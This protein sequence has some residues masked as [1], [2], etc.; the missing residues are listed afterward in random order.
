VAIRSLWL[1][2]VIASAM[3]AEARAQESD[4]S[5]V[6]FPPDFFA[7]FSPQTALD[8]VERVPGFTI[9]EGTERRGFAGAAGNVWID[10]AAPAVKSEDLDEILDRIP[11]RDVVRIELIRG[12]GASASNAQSV[13]VNVVRR[14]SDGAGVWEFSLQQ[15][16]GGEVS[17]AGQASWSGRRGAVEY[18]L[19]AMFEDANTPLDGAEL[20]YDAGVVLDER[21]VEHIE[22][23]ERERRIS[24]ELTSPF[25][26]GA[27]ALTGVL[28]SDEGDERHNLRS[29]DELGVAEGSEIVAAH[30]REEIGEVG[31]AYT[32]VLGA[33]ETELAALVTRRRLSEEEASVEY[34]ELGAFDESESEARDVESGETILRANAEREFAE[35]VSLSAGAEIALNTLDQ[36]LALT[37]DDGSGPT[38]VN[39]PGANVNIEEWRGEAFATLGLRALGWRMEAGAAVETSRLTQ[40][41]DVS[42]TMSLTYWKPSLQL[43]RPMGDDDQLR[44]RFYRDVG[45][46]DFEDFAAS[47]E[48][49]GGGGVFAGNPNLRPET[50]WRAEASSDWRFEEGAFELTLYYWRIED[51]LDYAPVGPPGDRFDARGN[52]G[53]ASLW[54]M[55][56][57]F[58]MPVPILSGANLRFEGVWQESEATDPLTGESRAQSEIRE[59]FVSVAFRQDLPGF[60]LAWGFDFERERL[61]PEYRFDRITRENDAD[62]TELWIESTHFDGV[63]LRVFAANLFNAEEARDR[64]RFYPDR[65]A[66]LDSRE[67][68]ERELGRVFGVELRGSF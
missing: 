18:T 59:S 32:R 38:L 40:S 53:E 7:S 15:S 48:L 60:S 22:E 52:I 42:N 30:E 57:A 45:Q 5:R 31:A 64:T 55:R 9:N 12:E 10:G 44:F 43:S 49:S 4:V 11:A 6:V 63:K 23:D 25:A 68:R 24:G 13:R 62:D 2:T 66:V 39:V 51:A 50:S 37:E 17:P 27:I 21:D 47:A 46:L 1:M 29:F 56:A 20:S 3:C 34:D 67:R 8:M 26:N 16:E 28:A 54:G 61:A 58:E 33:W 19:S 14:P 65:T 41:G 36:T 35:G